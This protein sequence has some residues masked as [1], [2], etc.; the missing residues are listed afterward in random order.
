MLYPFVQRLS[1]HSSSAGLLWRPT[2]DSFVR[3]CVP[4]LRWLNRHTGRLDFLIFHP[5]RSLRP[6][7][8]W[9]GSELFT[10]WPRSVVS[11]WIFVRKGCQPANANVCMSEPRYSLSCNSY[12]FVKLHCND[13]SLVRFPVGRLIWMAINFKWLSIHFVWMLSPHHTEPFLERRSK[14]IAPVMLS[15]W[16]LFCLVNVSIAVGW[17]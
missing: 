12:G 7:F 17:V 1:S 8:T 15:R 6:R 9:W 5:E 16:M 4:W 2:V 11:K 13:A 10:V 14:T 3:C